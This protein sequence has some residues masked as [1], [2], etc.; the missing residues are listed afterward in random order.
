V[1][2]EL[3]EEDGKVQHQKEVG[4][5]LVVWQSCFAAGDGFGGLAGL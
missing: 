4:L 3:I 1:T 5:A 2:I